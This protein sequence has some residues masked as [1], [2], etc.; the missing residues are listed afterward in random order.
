M[1]HK[2]EPTAARVATTN[3]SRRG[4]DRTL[5]HEE[6]AG[7]PVSQL[8]KDWQSTNR[9]NEVT[10]T[11]ARNVELTDVMDR[12]EQANLHEKSNG[13]IVGTRRLGSPPDSSI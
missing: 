1:A 5:T 4:V 11:S 6:S 9:S 2:G 13:L 10:F 12:I 3:S 8:I 7:V